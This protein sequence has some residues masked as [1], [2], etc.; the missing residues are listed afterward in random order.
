MQFF[1][2][3][4]NLLNSENLKSAFAQLWNELQVAILLWYTWSKVGE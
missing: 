3:K 4:T 2:V 1:W